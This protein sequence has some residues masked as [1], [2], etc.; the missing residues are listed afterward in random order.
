MMNTAN[1]KFWTPGTFLLMLLLWAINPGT[2]RAEAVNSG[3]LLRQAYFSLL[4][5]DHD[6]NGHR[7]EAL[8]EIETAAKLLKIELRGDGQGHERQ[9]VSDEQLRAARSLLEQARGGLETQPRKHVEK[10]IKQIDVAL[11]IR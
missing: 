9:G 5:A 6:Y 2:S 1:L 11:K 7:I 8:K 10:A 3:R 4:L